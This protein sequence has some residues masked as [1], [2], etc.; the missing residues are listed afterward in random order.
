M[1][2]RAVQLAQGNND[3]DYFY[4]VDDEDGDDGKND[5]NNCPNDDDDDCQGCRL[6][7]G[8]PVCFC[9]EGFTFI[10]VVHHQAN[11]HIHGFSE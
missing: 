5:D 3:N 4:D 6:E 10:Q 2:A 1:I 7:E 8:K 11:C 9:H